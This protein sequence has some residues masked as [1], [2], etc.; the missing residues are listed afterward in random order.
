MAG[1]WAS[2]G[3]NQMLHLSDAWA[4]LFS[5]LFAGVRKAN[6]IS[7]I[8]GASILPTPFGM[9]KTIGGHNFFWQRKI[10]IFAQAVN[11]ELSICLTVNLTV[12]KLFHISLTEF[13]KIKRPRLLRLLNRVYTQPSSVQPSSWLQ[14]YHWLCWTQSF[15]SSMSTTFTFSCWFVYK[16]YT[17]CIV[18]TKPIL[19]FL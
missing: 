12:S 16:I 1:T 2:T 10:G 6:K 13:W 5:T 9:N 17:T 19:P 4:S 11:Y 14:F 7:C 3:I 15:S 18:Y 8:E